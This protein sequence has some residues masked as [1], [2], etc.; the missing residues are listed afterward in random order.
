ME[1]LLTPRPVMV[2]MLNNK[3]VIYIERRQYAQ[4]TKS[5]SRALQ[6]AEKESSC[7]QQQQ[8][9]QQLLNQPNQSAEEL[10]IEWP[11]VRKELSL[12]SL[13]EAGANSG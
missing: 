10:D 6:M 4:A 7:V 1:F 5:L 8:Q 12:L 9:Q 13:N 11:N 3:G 2:S